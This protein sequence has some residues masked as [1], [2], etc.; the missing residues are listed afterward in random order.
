M[1]KV[2]AW[3]GSGIVLGQGALLGQVCLD[4]FPQRLCIRRAPSISEFGVFDYSVGSH[5]GTSLMQRE[6][7]VRRRL[8]CVVAPIIPCR[9]D[10]DGPHQR[11]LPCC[12]LPLAISLPALRRRLCVCVSQSMTAPAWLTAL[13]PHRQLG[14]GVLLEAALRP[15]PTERRRPSLRCTSAAQYRARSHLRDAIGER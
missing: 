1:L 7:R 2:R 9:L 8:I 15:I 5:L 3:S 11:T 12:T 4:L 14:R 10:P 13:C 6:S